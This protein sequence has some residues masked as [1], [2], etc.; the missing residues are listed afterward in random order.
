MGLFGPIGYIGPIGLIGPIDPH[1][2]K[3]AE[4]EGEPSPHDQVQR[5][6]HY[7]DDTDE[8]V[9]LEKRLIDPFQVELGRRPMLIKQG[10]TDQHQRAKVNPAK[11]AN[12]A[13]ADKA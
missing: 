11:S 4:Y 12:I 8:C 13:E 10:A 3:A 1:C 5:N 7:K 6:C 9:A 2:P